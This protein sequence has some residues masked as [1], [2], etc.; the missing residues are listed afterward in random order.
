MHL[1]LTE[2]AALGWVPYQHHF[3]YN[4]SSWLLCML[5]IL[6]IYVSVPC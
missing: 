6:Y 4:L 2:D 3:C 5:I 1:Y